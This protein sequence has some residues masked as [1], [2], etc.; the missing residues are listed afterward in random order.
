MDGYTNCPTQTLPECDPDEPFTDGVG[1][2]VGFSLH[3]GVATQAHERDKLPDRPGALPPHRTV[4]S[5]QALLRTAH[6]SLLACDSS[7]PKAPVK[8]PVISRLSL[9]WSC[10]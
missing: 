1:K 9:A 3:A 5:P 2:V 4:T 6:A 10:R 8:E 7:I